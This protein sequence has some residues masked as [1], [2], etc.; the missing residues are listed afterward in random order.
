MIPPQFL[1]VMKDFI[2]DLFLTFPE[3]KSNEDLLKIHESD[4]MD[5]YQRVFDVA[6]TTLPLCTMD[7]LQEK[8]TLFSESRIFLPNVDFKLLWND[9]I[10]DKT[11]AIIWKYLKLTLM[12]ILGTVEDGDVQEKMKA[13]M[14]DMKTMFEKGMPNT[15]DMHE[16]LQGMMNG[17]LGSLAKEIAEETVG[18]VKEEETFQ[19]LMKDPSKLFGL[20]HT[21]GDKIEKKIKSGELKESELIEEASEMFAKMKDM[22]GLKQFEALFKGKMN[23][24]AMQTKMDQNLK[25]AKMKERLQKKLA[26]RTIPVQT[27]AAQEKV[28]KKKKNKNKKNKHDVLDS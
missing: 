21:V 20:V 9:T 24:G 12:S 18:D 14:D 26:E 2:A 11:K 8:E 19:N 1:K 10:T 5:S 16:T 22:P 17:K 7:I 4:D 25:K 28:E 3:L 27:E 23:M 13:A 6:L 15:D